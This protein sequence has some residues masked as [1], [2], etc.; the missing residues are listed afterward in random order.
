[1]SNYFNTLPL[2]RQLDELGTCRF[3]DAAEFENGIN[4]AK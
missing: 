1:M 3:M 2:R 4:A